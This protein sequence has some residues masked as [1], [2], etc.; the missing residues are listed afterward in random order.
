MILSNATI[1]TNSEQFFLT[2]SVL[3]LAIGV[4]T[5]LTSVKNA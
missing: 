3:Q 4:G 5:K 1:C 2:A